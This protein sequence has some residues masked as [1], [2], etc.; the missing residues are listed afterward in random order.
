MINYFWK[1]KSLFFVTLHKTAS[2]FFAQFI[3][4]KAKKWQHK[5]YAQELFQNKTV[6]V[7][8]KKRGYLYGVIRLSLEKGNTYEKV[9]RPILDSMI[10]YKSN[11]LFFLRD[12]RDVLVS[13]FY[14]MA[15]SHDLSKNPQS[16]KLQIE[17]RKHALELGVDQWALWY[18]DYLKGYFE[19]IF[20]VNDKNPK[21]QILTYEMMVLN[22]EEMW[23]KISK[24]LS[25]PESLKIPFIEQ[26]RPIKTR[27]IYKHRRDGRPGNYVESLKETTVIELEKKLKPVL[28]RYSDISL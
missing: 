11:V 24:I 23:G 1:P 3:L 25:L 10:L 20:D 26:T 13:Y 9:V 15:Y 22:P 21:S 16:K 7:T 12:P 17:N 5:D 8:Y 2:S 19:Y 6:D 18:A 28:I 27:D 4:P 14:S